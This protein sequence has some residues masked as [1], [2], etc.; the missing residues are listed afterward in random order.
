MFQ[1]LGKYP[2]S[3]RVFPDLILFLASLKPS[4]EHG[5][6]RPV[7]IVGGKE[8][9]FRNFI[10]AET[11]EDLSFYLRMPLPTLVLAQLMP[12]VKRTLAHGSSS[13]RATSAK[14]TFSK[15]APLLLMVSNDDEV[16]PDIF[17]LKDANACH[18]KNSAIT[19]SVWKNQLDNHL[20]VK[21][22]DLH[23]CCYARQA[24]VDNVVNRRPQELL[25]VIEKIRGECDVV[26][27]REKAR[28]EECEELRIKCEATMTD[29]EKNPTAGY[30]V[31]L[32]TLESKVASLEAKKTRLETIEAS[33]WQ[34]V[35]DV[36][37]DRMEMLSKV[38]PYATLELVHND[39]LGSLVSK[40]VSFVVFYK[41]CTAFEQ[42]AE[43]KE[44]FDLSKVKGYCPLYKKEHTQPSNDLATITF[45]F[46]SEFVADPSALIE[47]LLSKK[48]LI[49]Q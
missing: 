15:D 47:V 6:H 3:I 10:Y 45:L 23:D 38:V 7:I 31:S 34:E 44:P 5:H 40:L 8:I 14:T 4:W 37:R 30:Q 13:S 9:A 41:R 27:E 12:L 32:L 46:I 16:L 29:F 49:L 35:D 42:V 22:M 25:Q 19:L 39:E 11:K 17:K 2:T 26:K 24:V 48:P 1:R 43:M 21:L 18:L 36:K 33:L 20:Y 28:E